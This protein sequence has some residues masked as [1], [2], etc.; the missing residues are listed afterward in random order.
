MSNEPAP[1]PITRL[2]P[3]L[4]IIALVIMIG[5][6]I[7]HVAMIAPPQAPAFE[8]SDAPTAADYA[9]ISGW[10]Q[11]P[12]NERDGG[13]E[14][15][16]GVDV[17][18]FP[19]YPGGFLGGWNVPLDW[20]GSEEAQNIPSW[21]P[22]AEALAS[23][24]FIPRRRYVSSMTGNAIDL[25]GAQALENEDILSAA[26][27]YLEN[28]HLMRGIFL[29]GSEDGVKA[30]MQVYNLRLNDTLPFDNLFGG[31]IIGSATSSSDVENLPGWPVCS[32]SGSYPCILDL[33]GQTEE[34][35]AQSVTQTLTQF[36]AWLDAEVPKPAAPLPPF[37]TI[38][39]S[40]IN[41]PDHEL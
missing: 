16:W 37:E 21:A 11:R 5:A 9:E 15:P 36:S 34:E 33:R 19:A 35:A 39:L 31:L 13:W 18:W 32:V 40:P 27:H 7:F 38:E 2:V 6:A 26:D 10:H 29:G 1:S 12:T 8:R 28:D 30:A 3:P 14:R 24:L 17:I 41:R 22:Q 25:Q 23:D 20:A 4:T